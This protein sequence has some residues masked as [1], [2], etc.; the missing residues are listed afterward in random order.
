MGIERITA[1]RV[2]TRGSALARRQTALAIDALLRAYPTLDVS[3]HIVRTVGDQ[4]TDVPLAEMAG[5]A[6]GVFTSAIEKALLDAQI[7]IAVHSAKDLPTEGTPGLILAAYLP[8]ASVHDV[9]ISRAGLPLMA[10]PRGAVVGTSSPRRAA[11]LRAHRPD[12]VIRDLRGNIDTR[13]EKALA[14]DGEYDAIVLAL[15]GLERL[16]RTDVI[17]EMLPLDVM[18]PAPAQGAICLQVRESQAWSALL[19]AVNHRATQTTITAE[20]AFLRGLGGG[21]ALPVGVHAQLEGTTLALR[22]RILAPDGQQQVE[23]AS[24]TALN[25]DWIGEAQI[26]GETLARQALDAGARRLMET[27]G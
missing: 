20:R 4:V 6:A 18:L 11:Q 12:L 24:T 9:L 8:R 27:A 14:S 3:E 25:A 5:G 15:A 23:V 19:Q 13:I 2:G 1:A 10:L 7:D 21:C 26:A 22:A 17:S 16:G